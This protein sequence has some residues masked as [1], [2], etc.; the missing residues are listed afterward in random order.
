MP[1]LQTVP[2]YKNNNPRQPGGD[3]SFLFLSDEADGLLF[4]RAVC[5]IYT[6]GA[7]IP[8]VIP[9]VVIAPISTRDTI[10]LEINGFAIVVDGTIEASSSPGS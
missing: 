2:V 8:A 1:V 3:Y 6:A 9:P 10:Q 4:L 5:V 7:N